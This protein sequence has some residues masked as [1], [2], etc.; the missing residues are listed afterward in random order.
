M[1]YFLSF[2]FLLRSFFLS[3]VEQYIVEETSQI[4]NFLMN[5]LFLSPS[6]VA[7]TRRISYSVSKSRH[8]TVPF[9]TTRRCRHASATSTEYTWG[10]RTRP[11]R[12]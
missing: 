10:R 7:A 9:L 5:K 11:F 12:W 8:Q 6:T 1:V 2:F 3:M 4:I